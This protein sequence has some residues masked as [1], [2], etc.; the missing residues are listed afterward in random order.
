MRAV[1]RAGEF[2]ALSP[3][4]FLALNAPA[5]PLLDPNWRRSPAMSAR[6]PLGLYERLV[7]LALDRQI[8]RLEPRFEARTEALEETE[9]PRLLARYV[10]GLLSL[11]LEARTGAHAK[12]QA[13]RP[14]VLASMS[15]L[16]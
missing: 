6:L 4:L 2:S 1:T 16:T 10:H 12:G 7:S 13:A 15:E 8:S 5:T 14:R 3:V 11:A 9:R